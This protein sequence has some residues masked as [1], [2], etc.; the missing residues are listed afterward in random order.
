MKL[1]LKTKNDPIA[2]IIDISIGN[3][4]NLYRC[5]LISVLDNPNFL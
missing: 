4:Y 5:D 1:K 3:E 2:A